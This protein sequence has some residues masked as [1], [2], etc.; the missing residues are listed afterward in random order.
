MDMIL[1]IKN[2][3]IDQL[4][5]LY[6]VRYT[7]H[8]TELEEVFNNNFAPPSSASNSYTN[9]IQSKILSSLIDTVHKITSNK[10]RC[11][12]II[13]RSLLLFHQKLYDDI[14]KHCCNLLIT[15]ERSMGITKQD[16]RKWSASSPLPHRQ[17]SSP[18]FNWETWIHLANKFGYAFSDF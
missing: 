3:L 16:K 15:K 7:I 10:E 11:L 12:S 13:S 18:S 17:T 4:S 8:Q 5:S 2:D 6:R 9:I 14:W 1:A